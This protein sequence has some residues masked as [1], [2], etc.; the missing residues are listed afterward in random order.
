MY[1]CVCAWSARRLGGRA[2]KRRRRKHNDIKEKEREKELERGGETTRVA[3]AP[4]LLHGEIAP[5]GTASRGPLL[6]GW[7]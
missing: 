5:P 2:A 7:R 3:A 4:P 1:V 6:I